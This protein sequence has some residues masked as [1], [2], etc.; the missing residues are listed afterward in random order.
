M[1]GLIKMKIGNITRRR[2]RCEQR[3]GINLAAYRAATQYKMSKI[4]AQSLINLTK[5][6]IT[7]WDDVDHE[8][9]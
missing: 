9:G 3:P 1:Y 7:A 2:R 5:L 6:T 8:T 4:I